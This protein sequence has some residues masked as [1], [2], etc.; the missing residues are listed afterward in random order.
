MANERR[1]RPGVGAAQAEGTTA[2]EDAAGAAAAAP[3]TTTKAP[4][5]VPRRDFLKIVGGGIVVLFTAGGWP[6]SSAEAQRGRPFPSD[7]N[8]YLRIGEDGTVTIFAG[9][10]EMGQGVVTSLAQ[11][12]A[13]ELRVPL[14]AI[15][16]VMGDTDLCPWDMGTFGSLTTR[17]FGPPLRAAAAEARDILLELA[18]ERLQVAPDELTAEGGVVSV[19]GEPARQVAYGQLARGREI[20]RR[21]QVEARLTRVEDFTVMGRATLRTDALEKVTGKALFTGDIRL[22]DLL[23]ATILRPPAHDAVLESV[24]TSAAEARPGV[25]VVRDGDLI[26]ILH[27][28]PEAA[29]GALR[30]VVAR[31]DVPEPQVDQ[32]TIFDHL[33]AAAPPAQE[34]E[35]RGDL[36][37]GERSAEWLVQE[38]YLDGYV[39]HAPM[40]THTAL[41]ALQE[42]RLTVWASTQT[43]FPTQERIARTVDLPADKVRVITPY[44]GGGFGGKSAGR[45]ADEAARLAVITGRPVQVAWNRAEEFFYDTFRPAAVVDIRSGVDGAGNICLWDYTVYFAGARGSDQYYD[46]PNNLIKVHGEW[47]G[48]STGAH[49][50]AVGPWRAP[51]AN[52]NTF[53]RES[54]I[55]AMAVR[56]AV[57][58]LEF[59]LKNTTD[60]RMLGVLNAAAERFGWQPGSGPGGRGRGPSDGDRSRGRGVACGIDAGTYVATMAEVEVDRTSGE[61]RVRRIVCA[62]D[63]GIVVNPAGATIQI[64]GCLTMGLGYAL[65]EEVRFQGGRI[66]DQNFD[67]YELPRFSWLPEIETVL[68]EN[69]GLAPQGGGEPAI[70]TVGAVVANAVFDATGARLRQLPMTPERVRNALAKG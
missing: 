24:D 27:P 8:A 10:I 25:R 12:A 67:T 42:G 52:T 11:M 43:P 16:M 60:A 63:M 14:D 9:K 51:G 47:M 34:R 26:A 50:F 4:W 55:D 33:V 15:R 22:P 17:F 6:I 2:A 3:A 39:A 68:V 66:L 21:S 46:V 54:Q 20:V 45:Q 13:E 61:I 53:A 70:V 1:D 69:D 32:S 29:A 57:D 37:A 59:R 65:T 36:A 49:P 19:A 31:W 7:P 41:A 62:Q 44:V 28:D 64:E 18:A 56:A 23:Y 48:G 58:P 40:E 38:R 5:L 35:R 30:D